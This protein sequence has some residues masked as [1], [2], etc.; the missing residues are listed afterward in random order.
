[1]LENASDFG[2]LI[3]L[4]FFKISFEKYDFWSLCSLQVFEK[5]VSFKLIFSP[6]FPSN[7]LERFACVHRLYGASNAGK[8]L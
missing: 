1:M 5:E 6:Y 4:R 2:N 7:N 8:M 3:L